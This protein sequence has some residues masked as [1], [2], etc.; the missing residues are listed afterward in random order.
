MYGTTQT[1]DGFVSY[2]SRQNA[3][4]ANR[5]QL[6][7]IYGHTPP[8]VSITSPVDGAIISKSGQ[9]TLTADAVATDGAMTS[10]AFYDGATLLGTDTSAPFSINP[11]LT[12]G[13]HF[14]KAIAT[15]ANNLSR[16]SLITRIDVAY[17]P[18]AN[19]STLTTPQAVPVDIDLNTLA[20]DVETP[21]S[22]L[23]LQLGSA[24]NG[25]VVMLAD[26]HTAR[27]TPAPGYGGPATF[28]YSVTDTTRD[29]RTLLN[30]AFQNSDVTDSSSQDR[31][32]TLTVQG[33]GA[34]T[35]RQRLAAHRLHQ[36]PR[37]HRKQHRRCRQTGSPAHHRPSRSRN[38]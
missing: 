33:T 5:P 24:T 4:T 31:D 32:A 26:G 19:A 35:F 30:Y 21:L 36:E 20:S 18:V 37:P 1:S 3:I 27:F 17:P 29:E 8:E 38:G 10:V 25:T 23:T 15:D 13:P 12:G 14:L 11:F 9:V 34:G 2:A 7:L 22:S 6:S 28:T 16:T